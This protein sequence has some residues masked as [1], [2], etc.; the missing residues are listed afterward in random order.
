MGEMCANCFVLEKTLSNESN[1][2][3]RL[4]KCSRCQQI[5]YCSRGKPRMSARTLEEGAQE[6]LQKGGESNS[7]GSSSCK[8]VELKARD[9]AKAEHWKIT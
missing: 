1:Q 8:L 9:S 5:K 6:A 7:S 3:T 2:T 4:M